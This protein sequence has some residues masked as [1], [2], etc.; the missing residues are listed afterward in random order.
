M[1]NIYSKL[2]EA[3]KIIRETKEKKAGHNSY[4]GY[5]YFTPEQV[6]ALVA[7]A[8][9]KTKTICVTNLRRDQYGYYQELRFIA[10]ENPLMATKQQGEGV[11]LIDQITFELR[12]E[13]PEIKATNAAQ[14]MGGM[15][16][17]SERYIKM[18]VFQIKDN[19]LDFD[20]QK[21]ETER[22]VYPSKATHP[23]QF[24]YKKSK[25]VGRE[26]AEMDTVQL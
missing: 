7:D 22:R 21:N 16:T 8:C 26:D 18:K 20:S 1:D 24:G 15:D 23:E 4:S 14:Q 13:P 25:D 9:E 3:R 12:T 17:Y 10:L 6:E 11:E 2:A 5:D 19:N